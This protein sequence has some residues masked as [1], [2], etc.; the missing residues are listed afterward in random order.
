MSIWEDEGVGS[1]SSLVPMR[2]WYHDLYTS[3]IHHDSRFPRERYQMLK[4][5]IK[6]SKDSY[7]IDFVP[8]ACASVNDLLMV[9]DADF[10][11]RFVEGE[12]DDR[13]INRIGLKPWTGSFIER[14]LRIMGGSISALNH[15]SE[16]GGISGNMAGGTHHSHVDFGSGYCVFNDIAV[17]AAI[18]TGTLGFSRVAVLDLDVHQGDGTA[19]MLT[20]NSDTLT[21]SVHCRDNFPFR[22]ANSDHDLPLNSGSG[23]ARYLEK[24]GE[25]LGLIDGFGPDL[26]LFQA[27]VDALE[28]DGLGKLRVTRKGMRVR[29]RMVFSYV[30]ERGLPCVVLMGGGYSD[31]ISHTVDAFFDL[32]I[33]GAIANHHIQKV[34]SLGPRESGM[35]WSDA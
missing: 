27:G 22:K 13:E 15:V 30:V 28:T 31:P 23:D 29:N 25:A 7:L 10:V 16:F 9:H 1:G 35:G 18:A 2:I 20:G 6:S 33:D 26:V 14:T 34:R 8:P 5:R 4:K 19:A 17:C 11:R 24:V 32:F 12:L 3:G 21:V